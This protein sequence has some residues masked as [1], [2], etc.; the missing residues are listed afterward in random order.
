MS[1]KAYLREFLFGCCFLLYVGVV[2]TA[3]I[4]K[5]LRSCN[6]KRIYIL[7]R[8]KKNMGIEARLKDLK[9]AMVRRIFSITYLF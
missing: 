6:V 3:L 9:N 8:P 4:E 5:L 1:L 2:G 7:L